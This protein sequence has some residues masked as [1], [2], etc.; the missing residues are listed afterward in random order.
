MYVDFH[1]HLHSYSDRGTASL[2][3]AE[4]QIL[5]VGCSVDISSYL[6][7]KDLAK[8]NPYIL[9]TFGIHPMRSGEVT[10]L[11]EID[12]SLQDSQLI[13]EIGLDNCWVKDVE[14]KAQERV[15]EYI[16]AHC[17]D[18]EKYCVIHTKDAERRVADL[19]RAFPK[20]KPIIHWYDGPIAVYE[21]LLSR[22]SSFTFG[23]EVFYSDHIKTLLRMTPSELVLSETDNPDSEK[24]LGGIS[25]SPKLI[26]RV[27]KDISAVKNIDEQEMEAILLANSLRIL[28]ESH[29]N[30]P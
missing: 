9:P 4:S 1:T 10:S 8:S 12:D 26:A 29:I 14:P 27:V 7:T 22:N 19:L 20:A 3:I 16:L 23:C 18:T 6:I 30:T 25:D 21:E 2:E 13:G 11:S 15:F 28:H 5:S 17:H 24:W